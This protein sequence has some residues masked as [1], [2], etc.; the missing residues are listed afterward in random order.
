MK[1]G[2]DPNYYDLQDG[3]VV[4]VFLGCS[5]FDNPKAIGANGQPI[6]PG[7]RWAFRIMTG[8]D[9]GKETAR[10]TQLNPTHKNSC[11]RM[12]MA[13]TDKDLSEDHPFESS[14]YHG[15][16]YAVSIREGKLQDQPSPRFIGTDKMT[17]AAAEDVLAGKH[18]PE[19]MV[20][21]QTQ[22]EDIPF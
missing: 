7:I 22:T 2:F 8:P 11:G 19:V 9:K 15:F 18:L 1:I 13:V 10:I 14:A 6:G 17:L 4:A 20:P 5:E 21:K 12:I 3:R 16:Y